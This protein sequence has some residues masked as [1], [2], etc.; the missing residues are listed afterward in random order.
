MGRGMRLATSLLEKAMTPSNKPDNIVLADSWAPAKVPSS[1]GG[2]KAQYVFVETDTQIEA[3]A[4]QRIADIFAQHGEPI[5]RQMEA[6]ICQ[7][8]AADTIR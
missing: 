4:G 5:F 2:R 8:A 7:R 3:Q 6:E 1:T